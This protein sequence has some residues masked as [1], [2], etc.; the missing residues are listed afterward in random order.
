MEISN[1]FIDRSNRPRSGWR[2]GIFTLLL[3]PITGAI[4]AASYPIVSGWSQR[5]GTSLELLS[6]MLGS[7]LM[8]VPAIGVGWFC[9]WK[10]EGLPFRALGA[11]FTNR[12]LGHFGLGCVFGGLTLLL[13]V[14][15]AA[16]GGGLSFRFNYE[17][18]SA[19]IMET[20]AVSMLLFAIAAAAEEA[21]FRGYPLQTFARSGYAWFAIAMTSLFFGLAHLSNPG[22]NLISTA[23]TILAGIW[24]GVAYL[25]TRD[26]WFVWG[27]HLV[28]NWI[29]GAVFGIEVSGLT[30]IT[31]SPLLREIDTGPAWL[32][33]GIYGLE[34]GVACT[35]ALIVSSIA[36]NF[37]PIVRPDPEMLTLTSPS[38]RTSPS[39][40]S[41]S[42]DRLYFK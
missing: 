15:A 10:L 24:F 16:A 21:M 17:A 29:Q 20:L 26:L 6:V 4:A 1:I 34:G 8:L 40:D 23:N 41:S 7:V 22:V 38:E 27:L 3:V 19:S 32:T 30:D 12:W 5:T 39:D 13:A 9:G 28:W 18:D 36:I 37:V 2:F 31:R 25:K 33:G 14:L 11:W 35:I 42:S